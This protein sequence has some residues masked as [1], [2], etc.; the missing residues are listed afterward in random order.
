[1]GAW[2]KSLEPEDSWKCFSNQCQWNSIFGPEISCWSFCGQYCCLPFRSSW[3]TG[4]PGRFLPFPIPLAQ[5]AQGLEAPQIG[6]HHQHTKFLTFF[7]QQCVRIENILPNCAKCFMLLP[8]DVYYP[9]VQN[10]LKHHICQICSK[11][12]L[13]HLKD[14]TM[15]V[16]LHWTLL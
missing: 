14:L 7:R 1:M 5:T 16:K 15:L 3:K 9:S 11:Y 10:N 2:W 13:K 6:E 4:V 8:S 12:C